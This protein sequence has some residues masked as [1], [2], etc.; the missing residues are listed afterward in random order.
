MEALRL[1]PA[2]PVSSE[3][4]LSQDAKIGKY[5]LKAGDRIILNLDGI[6]RNSNEW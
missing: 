3:Y 1:F 6:A 5:N 4:S 2:T